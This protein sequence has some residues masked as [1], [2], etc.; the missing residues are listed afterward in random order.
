MVELYWTRIVDDGISDL[1]DIEN[2]EKVL[3]SHPGL[4]RDKGYIGFCGH[5]DKLAFRNLRIKSLD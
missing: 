5:G 3:A 1:S 2:A 4:R